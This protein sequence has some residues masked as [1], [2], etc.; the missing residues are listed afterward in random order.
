MYHVDSRL[1]KN[2]DDTPQT[3][4]N[5]ADTQDGLNGL[6]PVTIGASNTNNSSR[7]YTVELFEQIELI[8]SNPNGSAYNRLITPYSA[9][10]FF[11]TGNTFDLDTYSYFTYEESGKLNNGEE[12]NIR[13][14]F[15][16]VSSEGADLIIEPL[17]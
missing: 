7:N 1:F 8:S 17:D 9:N 13:I 2:N 11:Q 10:D 6:G 4:I 5:L 15:E 16:N 12:L 3:Y 14:Y